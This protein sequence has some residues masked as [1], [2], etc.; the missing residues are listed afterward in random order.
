MTRRVSPARTCSRKREEPQG[1]PPE[2]EEEEKV[3]SESR[4]QKV[5]GWDTL[6]PETIRALELRL[7]CEL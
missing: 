7:E 5:V 2:E 1:P 6:I 4:C 3:E